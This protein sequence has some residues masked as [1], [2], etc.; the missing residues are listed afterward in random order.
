MSIRKEFKRRG[1]MPWLKKIICVIAVLRRTVVCDRR[2]ENL[3]APAHV[4]KRMSV[5]NYDVIS[6]P[7]HCQLSTRYS[8]LSLTL[9]FSLT[10]YN[11]KDT[12]F[13]W[14]SC[15]YMRQFLSCVIQLKWNL[16][17]ENLA[18]EYSSYPQVFGSFDGTTRS[19]FNIFAIQF[20]SVR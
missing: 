4:V 18:Y 17:L 2:F 20:L 7:T 3:M 11:A 5:K 1:N 10:I 9:I 14:A 13:D 19:F 15:V 6:L 16:A 8:V 12:Y